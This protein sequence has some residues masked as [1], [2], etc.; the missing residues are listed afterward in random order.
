VYPAGYAESWNIGV[1]NCC[2][3]AVAAH[4]DDIAFVRQV[5]LAVSARLHSSATYLVGFSN[6]GKLAYQVMC[7]QP[8]L[9][10]ALVTVGAT[11]L[12]ACPDPIPRPFLMT[13]GAEDPELPQQGQAQPVPGLLAST[14]ATWTQY[15]HCAGAPTVVEEGT[16]TKSTWS[17]CA[18]GTKVEG[19]LYSGLNHRWPTA[20]L[21]G[22][23]VSGAKLIW[24][25]VSG[26]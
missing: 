5:T 3:P 20:A 26:G 23:S 4:L 6:G 8:Q 2:G 15:D 1:A 14:L 13:V 12:A 7:E 17:A 21:V 22:A 11:P 19:V 10:E 24:S 9:F 16:A 18:P 25:F